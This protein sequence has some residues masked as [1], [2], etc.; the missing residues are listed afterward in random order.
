MAEMEVK[1]SYG[2]LKMQAL[3]F[4]MAQENRK[5]EDEL[6]EHLDKLYQKNVPKQVQEFLEK[7]PLDAEEQGA[8]VPVETAGAVAE[9]Q[10]D[11]QAEQQSGQQPEQGAT[12]NTTE[13]DAG[14]ERTTS[15]ARATGRG[16][17]NR[18]TTRAN[19]NTQNAGT[20]SRANQTHAD[21]VAE[22]N[23]T[24]QSA[25]AGTEAEEVQEQTG[26]M[27]MGM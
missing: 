10:T 6:K 13:A 3:E 2:A 15:T 17:Q 18:N 26:G 25:D 19:R 16:S 21:I 9:N 24:E 7:G 8:V 11:N 1:V 4:Y 20:G 14:N 5:I 23:E 27:V 12:Q 22:Q